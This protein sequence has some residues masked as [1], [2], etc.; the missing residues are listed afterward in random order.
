MR[1]RNPNKPGPFAGHPTA[2]PLLIRDGMMWFDRFVRRLTKRGDD[3]VINGLI[4]TPVQK[5]A[6]SDESLR[7]KA[8][9]RTARAQEKRHDAARIASGGIPEESRTI[10]MAGR[11]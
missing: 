5:Y 9:K 6:G 2:E 3:R 4:G 10:R 8:D 7:V 1:S 11:R